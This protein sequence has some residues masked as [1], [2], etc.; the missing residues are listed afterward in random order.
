MRKNRISLEDSKSLKSRRPSPVNICSQPAWEIEGSPNK[1][2]KDKILSNIKGRRVLLVRDPDRIIKSEHIEIPSQK[3][4]FHIIKG[5]LELR[6]VLQVSDKDKLVIVDQ[7][8]TGSF[9][10]DLDGNAECRLF[11]LSI[12]EFLQERTGIHSWPRIVREYP[13]REI[14]KDKWDNFLRVVSERDNQ[15]Q[16]NLTDDSI[17]RMA[18]EA[19]LGFSMVV[20]PKL[21]DALKIALSGK[22]IWAK[23]ISYF[24]VNEAKE[25]QQSSK[26]LPH[27]INLLLDPNL[28]GPQVSAIGGLSILAQHRERAGELIAL[29][30]PQFYKYS[31]FENSNLPPKYESLQAFQEAAAKFEQSANLS[32]WE[33]I[34]EKLNL[35]DPEMAV[36]VIEKEKL[37]PRIGI[38]CML[39]IIGNF[40][41]GE[42]LAEKIARYKVFYERLT[43]AHDTLESEAT[44]QHLKLIF[45]KTYGCYRM[46]NRLND[47]TRSL[48]LK[49][50]S[51]LEWN[52]IIL[53]WVD[54][55]LC[56]TEYSVASL[57]KDWNQISFPEGLPGWAK[58][59]GIGIGPRLTQLTEF[60]SNLVTELNISFQRL[61]KTRYP[62]DAGRSILTTSE[63]LKDI[64]KPILK[65]R[66]TQRPTVVILFD[67]MRYDFWEALFKPILES[68]FEMRKALPALSRLPS[69]TTYS[70]RAAFSGLKPKD[71]SLNAAEYGLL[72]TAIERLAIGKGKVEEVKTLA[73]IS[74][75]IKIAIRIQNIEF[76]FIVLDLS[77]NLP[78]N[79]DY[80]LPELFNMIKGLS[81]TIEA[82]INKLP[83]NP[84]LFVLSDHGFTKLGRKTVTIREGDVKYRYA[85]LKNPPREDIRKKS[86]M[87]NSSDLCLSGNDIFLFP[88]VG[89][90]FLREGG[91]DVN[92]FYYHGGI[93]L[94]EMIIPFVH[95]STRR[96]KA[97]SVKIDIECDPNY[98][99]G[100]KGLVLTTL[101]LEEQDEAE[102]EVTSSLPNFS[103]RILLLKEGKPKELLLEFVPDTEGVRFFT[104][105]ITERTKI[106]GSIAA[107]LN[108]Q[109]PAK[110]EREEI[111]GLKEIFGD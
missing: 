66:K 93:S 84:D 39:T 72:Q 48:K 14:C 103:D 6:K 50:E 54:E 99:V 88:T 17:R 109:V 89:W 100:K 36:R 73:S 33:K 87:F 104:V 46:L 2:A 77:D 56:L 101:T 8:T 30:D 41:E 44:Y 76:Y 58:E 105:T 28:S 60:A 47:L 64:V 27:P 63:F 95:L 85:L 90:T 74:K 18:A 35:S 29:I 92:D 32:Y 26:H 51:D 106:L 102:V 62:S 49:K 71:F 91:G 83:A 15:G 55:N 9:V 53:P 94:E 70:R 7:S 67:G 4:S 59:L 79:I 97:A 57:A 5:N 3:L 43:E 69:N 20:E 107:S 31:S 82:L 42:K 21:E 11:E 80:S 81:G 24:G 13:C 1:W 22:I 19:V 45:K 96:R 38:V 111:E 25:L 16:L 61:V 78:H 65:K 52:L 12:T 10:P 86:I 110:I 37:S 23:L 40:L 75:S 68:R 108:V 34:A 98:E